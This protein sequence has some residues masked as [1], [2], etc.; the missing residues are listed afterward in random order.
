MISCAPVPLPRRHGHGEPTMLYIYYG[1]PFLASQ[2]RSS[3]P[4]S[5]I[6]R[7]IALAPVISLLCRS[8][9]LDD[10]VVLSSFGYMYHAA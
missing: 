3:G 7:H 5:C 9:T 6:R 1:G 8:M 4:A 2:D 10:D